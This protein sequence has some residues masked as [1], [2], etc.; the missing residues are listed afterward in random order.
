MCVIIRRE[1]GIIIPP[2]KIDS[3]CHVNG[4]GYGFSVVD[5]GKMTTIKHHQDGG[6]NHE[7]I[8]KHLEDAKDCEVFL[9][10]RFT[11][12]G[13]TNEA[14]CHPFEAFNG[15]NYQVMFMHN[16]TLHK[17]KKD[18]DPYSDSYHFNERILKPLL[19]RF[20]EVDGAGV[21]DNPLLADILESFQGGSAFMLYDNEG[22]H[23]AIENSSCKQFEGW[24]ASNEYSFNR[25]HREPT[26][27]YYRGADYGERDPFGYR[28]Y[29][30]TPPTDTTTTNL[31]TA[32][33]KVATNTNEQCKKT[34]FAIMQAKRLGAPNRELTPPT[35]RLTFV[36][37]ADLTELRD[38]MVMTEGDIYDLVQELP[39]A[40]T[41][42]IMD[43]I[44]ELYTK[45]AK[46][47]LQ[48]VTTNVTPINKEVVN[49]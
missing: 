44:H 30:P 16:G 17:F 28:R 34:G 18:K 19:R 37:L 10:L 45:D 8:L 29:T 6:N 9:H 2:T 26:T 7:E 21:L 36:E 48:Q 32:T 14:N 27:T 41:A 42:L 11:T 12:A 20:Y 23:L 49:G 35:K 15:D 13:E 4:D 38:V 25:T 33:T 3:A 46:E 1:P 39:L 31:P 24:W 47:K 22:N 5:R 40:G 43:L